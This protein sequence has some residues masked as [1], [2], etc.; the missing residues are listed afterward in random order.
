V[1]ADDDDD[2]V[3]MNVLSNNNLTP[4]VAEG[5]EATHAGNEEAMR[6]QSTGSPGSELSPE[7]V[8]PEASGLDPIAAIGRLQ[9]LVSA[10]RSPRT[11]SRQRWPSFS[12]ASDR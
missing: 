1:L 6:Q 7:A 11:S 4:L 8:T 5:A 3:R 12:E 9:D 2:L 10:V